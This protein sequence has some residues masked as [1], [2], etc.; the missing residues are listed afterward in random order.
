VEET[1]R[2]VAGAWAV[3]GQVIQVWAV[4]AEEAAAVAVVDLVIVRFV[5][6]V[7]AWHFGL[8]AIG[9]VVGSCPLSGQPCSVY[10]SLWSNIWS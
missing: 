9:Q 3:G 2:R 8:L 10:G 4:A 6:N 7:W 1:Q 5:L